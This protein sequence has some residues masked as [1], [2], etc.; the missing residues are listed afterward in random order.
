MKR[1]SLLQSTKKPHGLGKA[2]SNDVFFHKRCV[3]MLVPDCDSF[4]MEIQCSENLFGTAYALIKR[5]LQ[6]QI[7]VKT[8]VLSYENGVLFEYT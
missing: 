7:Q 1:D 8:F 5:I 6:K 3:L 4:V 2:L